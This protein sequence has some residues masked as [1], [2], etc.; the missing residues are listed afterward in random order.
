MQSLS[1]AA[2]GSFHD[3]LGS[4]VLELSHRGGGH[5]ATRI[6]ARRTHLTQSPQACTPQQ[7]VT[8][9]N[10][11]HHQVRH[12]PLALI[13]SPPLSKQFPVN[14]PFRPLTVKLIETFI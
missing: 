4:E 5:A 14:L 6:K 8:Q 3:H 13:K 2:K 1:L 11:L 10:N 9:N 7:P 12:H